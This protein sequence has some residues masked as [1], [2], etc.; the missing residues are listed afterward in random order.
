[1]EQAST[2]DVLQELA[3]SSLG[4]T[5]LQEEAD[6]VAKMQGLT[7]SAELKETI[8]RVSKKWLPQGRRPANRR[9]CNE[10]TAEQCDIEDAVEAAGGKR[11]Q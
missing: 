6:R 7:P 8:K 2:R 9:G 11:G 10:P 5:S 1:M 3:G 4:S